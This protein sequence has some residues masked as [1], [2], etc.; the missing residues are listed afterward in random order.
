[1]KIQEINSCSSIIIILRSQRLQQ[2]V[3]AAPAIAVKVLA[4]YDFLPECVAP[5]SAGREL[6]DMLP[7]AG[8]VADIVECAN[9]DVALIVE[10]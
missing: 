3:Q 2:L 8:L 6:A 7:A 10:R 1:M 5:E 9:V 4:A